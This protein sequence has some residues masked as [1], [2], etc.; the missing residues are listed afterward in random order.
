MEDRT[1]DAA[2]GVGHTGAIAL[3]LENL[4]VNAVRHTRPG[5]AIV[6]RVGPDASVHVLDDGDRIPD[7][8][9]ARLTDRFWRAD[10]SRSE[11]SGI[12]LSIVDRVARAHHGILDVSQRTDDTGL[13][14]RITLG[15]VKR[16]RR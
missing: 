8:H 5:T 14:F 1:S 16:H 4:V 10:G 6:V 11:G 13:H 3:A 2:F 12:G 9:L 15:H 7:E